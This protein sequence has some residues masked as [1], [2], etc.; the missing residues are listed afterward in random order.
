MK[1]FLI[2]RTFP[3][4][5]LEGLDQTIKDK[6]NTANADFDV[7]WIRSYA[8]AQ[9]T[10]TFCVY[11]GPSEQAIRDAAAANALPVDE[12]FE[13]PVDLMPTAEPAPA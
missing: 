3:A 7:T 4:G 6:V 11:E 1:R 10:L 2:K 12:I 5:A 9:R 13:I 8:N